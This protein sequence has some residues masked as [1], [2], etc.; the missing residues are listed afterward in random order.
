MSGVLRS[1]VMGH[2]EHDCDDY[3]R[4]PNEFERL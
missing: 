3:V 2:W 1:I 4:A